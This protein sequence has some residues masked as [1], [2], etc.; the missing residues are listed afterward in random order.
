[1]FYALFLS[2]FQLC[3]NCTSA[4]FFVACRPQHKMTFIKMDHFSFGQM[5]LTLA[6]KNGLAYKPPLTSRGEQ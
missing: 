3:R 1:M 6:S 2:L 5:K 4:E